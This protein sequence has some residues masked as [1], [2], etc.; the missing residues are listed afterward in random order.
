MNRSSA[1]AVSDLTA[2]ENA[3]DTMRWARSVYEELVSDQDRW[4]EEL[5]WLWYNHH[6]AA[7]LAA[8]RLLDRHPKSASLMGIV[9]SV[10]DAGQAL[11]VAT[12]QRVPGGSEVA[13]DLARLESV[14][15][16]VADWA[17]KCVAHMDRSGGPRRAP[18]FDDIDQGLAVMI[19]VFLRYRRLLTGD[20][21]PK[22][23]SDVTWD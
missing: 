4:T 22:V 9:L 18:S 19:D 6:Q 11:V 17:N 7:V 16:S 14:R 15:S 13:A 2:V 23:G 12:G 5:H 3:L 8:R 10:K 21:S 1:T 20:E